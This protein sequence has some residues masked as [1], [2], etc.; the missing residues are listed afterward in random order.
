MP[1]HDALEQAV[2][3]LEG[4]LLALGEALCQPHAEAV[5][6]EAAELQRA[7]EPL[8]RHAGDGALT[9][10]LRQRLALAAGLAGAQRD[11][12]AR[13]SAALERAIDVLLPPPAPRSAYS[14]AGLSERPSLGGVLQA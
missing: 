7:L 8:R 9:P 10:P 6:A 13:T 11:A 4:R 14:A 3:R 5:A 1:R 2:A 12:L